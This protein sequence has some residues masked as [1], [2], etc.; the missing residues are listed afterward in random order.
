MTRSLFL[1]VGQVAQLVV[2]SSVASDMFGR[3]L[4]QY[5]VP[6]QP[7]KEEFVSIF[8]VAAS[9][10]VSSLSTDGFRYVHLQ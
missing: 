7:I 10:A 4:H 1:H 5:S 6:T 8:L 3:K 2:C 9:A